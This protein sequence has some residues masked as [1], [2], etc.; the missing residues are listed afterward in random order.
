MWSLLP[1][2]TYACAPTRYIPSRTVYSYLRVQYIGLKKLHLWRQWN[3]SWKGKKPVGG[4]NEYKRTQRSS[5]SVLLIWVPWLP[6]YPPR[7]SFFSNSPTMKPPV[8]SC[9]GLFANVQPKKPSYSERLECRSGLSDVPWY[10]LLCLSKFLEEE[11]R[12]IS[13]RYTPVQQNFAKNAL[14]GH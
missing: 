1:L 3:S 7:V 10:V 9:T 8:P 11:L 6:P 14:F 12:D 2:L 4:S 5:C 13:I